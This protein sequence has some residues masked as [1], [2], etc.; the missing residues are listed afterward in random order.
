VRVR[1][2]RLPAFVVGILSGLAGLNHRVEHFSPP[3]M[4]RVIDSAPLTVLKQSQDNP[5]EERP[6]L[7]LEI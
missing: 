2:H 7:S 1:A 6:L 3:S 4:F 5:Q